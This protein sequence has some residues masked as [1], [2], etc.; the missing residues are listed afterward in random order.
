MVV[1]SAAAG[2]S[3]GGEMEVERGR[4]L[5]DCLVRWSWIHC[6]SDEGK[7]GGMAVFR[8]DFSTTTEVTCLSPLCGRETECR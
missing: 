8:P 5:I 3:S 6:R 7:E 1:R 2:I 4:D